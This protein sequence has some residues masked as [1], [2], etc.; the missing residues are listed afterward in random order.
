MI[1][2]LQGYIR[3]AI[4]GLSSPKVLMN[5]T[6]VECNNF[7]VGV[8]SKGIKLVRGSGNLLHATIIVW[9]YFLMA[10][11]A[12]LLDD[13]LDKISL[14]NYSV[15]LIW[16]LVE[17]FIGDIFPQLISLAAKK[18]DVK[19]FILARISF[20][21]F[22]FFFV[23]LLLLC[24]PIK[25]VLNFFWVYPGEAATGN[26]TTFQNLKIQNPKILDKILEKKDKI[27]SRYYKKKQADQSLSIITGHYM[28][29][30]ISVWRQYIFY[31]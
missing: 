17:L 15:A 30:P 7:K 12:V 25:I 19:K 8:F 23:A 6:E 3:Y 10:L 29:C 18:C 24:Y 22:G 27:L 31:E 2:G 20:V 21:I 4:R 13:Q 14:P 26:H 28:Q 16:C 5:L 9:K 1:I 11:G